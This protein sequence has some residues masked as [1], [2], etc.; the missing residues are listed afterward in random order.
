MSPES[1]ALSNEPSNE[2]VTPDKSS[3]N[4]SWFASTHVESRSPNLALVY[5]C[6][7]F[8]PRPVNA[9][10]S[11]STITHLAKYESPS[12]LNRETNDQLDCTSSMSSRSY[13]Y[14]AGLGLFVSADSILLTTITPPS[15]ATDVPKRNL[16][17]FVPA[18]SSG[19]RTPT[20]VQLDEVLAN[21]KA[22]PTSL[23]EP[24][25]VFFAPTTIVSSVLSMAT[26]KPKSLAVSSVNVC[27]SVHCAS[28]VDARFL[29]Y[30]YTAW[31]LTTEDP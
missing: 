10:V 25:S 26:E 27:A 7:I 29:V 3:G 6:T 9:I 1:A 28:D 24:R 18:G 21:T 19:R 14:A 15:I 2:L 12:S 30:T 8:F 22:A 13:T 20:W 17:R 23:T 16:A 5:T 4:A 11:P 31:P